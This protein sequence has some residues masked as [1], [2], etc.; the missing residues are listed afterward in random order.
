MISGEK[1]WEAMSIMSIN[2][3]GKYFYKYINKQNPPSTNLRNDTKRKCYRCGSA[4][5]RDHGKNCKA[6]KA[7]C[8]SCQKI[9]HYAKVCYQWK[10]RVLD[11][12]DQYTQP[13]NLNSDEE[14]YEMSLW[15]VDTLKYKNKKGSDDFKFSSGWHRSKDISMWQEASSSIGHS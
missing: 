8:S 11:E 12:D 2:K 15:A 9:G 1:G 7:I 13:N 14:L 10:V 4:Y 5:T 6:V 3:I